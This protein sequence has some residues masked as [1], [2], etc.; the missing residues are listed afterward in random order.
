MKWILGVASLASLVAFTACADEPTRP[1]DP[2]QMLGIVAWDDPPAVVAAVSDTAVGKPGQADGSWWLQ[3]PLQVPDTVTRGIPFTIV[4]TTV[5][6][7]CFEAGGYEKEVVG[8]MATI[9]AYDLWN[10]SE[11]CLQVARFFRRTVELKFDEPGEAV[12][13]LVGRRVIGSLVDEGEPKVVDR[14][15]WVD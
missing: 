15:V 10:G 6:D 2:M 11:I 12:V 5:G 13:R 1:F 4:A 8:G 3:G 14:T 9:T 7:G